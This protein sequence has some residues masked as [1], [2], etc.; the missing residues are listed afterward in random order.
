MINLHS[1][2]NI[3]CNILNGKPIVQKHEGLEV[4][5]VIVSSQ[6]SQCKIYTKA[7]S[8][9]PKEQEIY[10]HYGIGYWLIREKFPRHRVLVSKYINPNKV[11]TE[12]DRLCFVQHPKCVYIEDIFTEYVS[13][14]NKNI[15]K[16]PE[17]TNESTLTKQSL[18][19]Y[20]RT[21]YGFDYNWELINNHLI[22]TT[23]NS[24]TLPLRL[25]KFTLCDDLIWWNLKNY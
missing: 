10:I 12:N 9:I 3:Y 24:D 17:C 2:E 11:N 25:G 22:L 8:D 6:D 5:A 7:I 4:N 1:L 19:L 20:V 23:P 15:I 14:N 16:F 13:N 18:E 21:F